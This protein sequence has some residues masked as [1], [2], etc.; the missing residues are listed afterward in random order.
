MWKK[1]EIFKN[2]KFQIFVLAQFC[3]L[4]IGLLAILGGDDVVYRQELQKEMANET[5]D[6]TDFSLQPGSYE[7]LVTYETT[8]EMVC[9]VGVYAAKASLY[10]LLANEVYLP[11]QKEACKF[12]FY[13][14]ER[15]DAEDDLRIQMKGHGAQRF[16]LKEIEV[17]KTVD[18]YLACTI[19]TFA[20]F[21]LTDWL[22]M[23]YV[24][25]GRYEVSI[26][27]KLSWFGLPCAALVAS[28]P[29]MVDYIVA[30]G[31]IPLMIQRIERLADG[32]VATL[33]LGDFLLLFPAL[34]RILGFPMTAAYSI[35]VIGWNLMV[36]YLLYWLW[37][38][39]FKNVYI[40]MV[41]AVLYIISPYRLD[42]IYSQVGTD[43]YVSRILLALLIA[44]MACA[45]GTW[46]NKR[47]EKTVKAVYF[48]ALV[49][50]GLFWS[51]L[52]SSQ[53]MDQETNILRPY[54]IE[55]FVDVER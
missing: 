46:L 38:R 52:H 24:Y 25:M 29:V 20:L 40:G 48:G 27:K 13:A 22:I 41:G 35:F 16:L 36:T 45:F 33:S 50:C 2:R 28:A 53:I 17:V 3:V 51:I 49:V 44:L 54:T 9:S 55:S 32:Q 31:H 15:L 39:M 42:V 10:G 4:A 8:G 18:A 11:A 6:L 26:V 34:L 5:M 1:S 37:K 21:G 23:L 19:A 12:Q 30:S 7:V 14:L 47:S 43:K